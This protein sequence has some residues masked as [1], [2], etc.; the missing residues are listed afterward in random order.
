[1]ILSPVPVEAATG[2]VA[3]IYAGDVDLFGHVTEHTKVMALNPEAH[4]AFEALVHAIQPSL[5]SR[6]YRLITLAAAGALASQPCLL[7]HGGFA[8]RQFDDEQ[9]E[10]IG[11]DFH[12]A[13]LT[14]AEVAMMDYAVKIS[15]DAAAMTDDDV[16]V[17]RGHGFDDRQILDI[18]LAAAARNYYSR[19]LS[20][21][22]VVD[23]VPASLPT[24]V[25]DALLSKA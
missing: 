16:A 21:L 19:A 5:G 8:R 25:R 12:D 17:L 18:T 14:E 10:R 23:E 13:G 22:G 9:L 24:G 1:M 2:E 6:A 11:R 20:A 4:H 3:E 7:A 15:T